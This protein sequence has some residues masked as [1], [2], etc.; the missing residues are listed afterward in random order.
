MKAT[1]KLT[2]EKSGHVYLLCEDGGIVKYKRL[3]HDGS[4][5]DG[6][7]STVHSSVEIYDKPGWSNLQKLNNFK[8]N[9]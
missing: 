3:F 6:W 2:Y 1:H 8:G 5:E 9:R 7:H 4:I